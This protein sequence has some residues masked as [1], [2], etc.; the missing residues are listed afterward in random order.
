MK[1]GD[2]KITEFHVDIGDKVYPPTNFKNEFDFTK[3]HISI[4]Y[5][6]YNNLVIKKNG[7]QNP[8]LNQQDLKTYILN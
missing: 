4:P 3:N 8:M 7:I 1:K 6:D 5:N 2:E